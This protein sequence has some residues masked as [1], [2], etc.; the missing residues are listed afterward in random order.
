M[1]KSP[2]TFERN[3]DGSLKLFNAEEL[4]PSLKSEYEFLRKHK[5]VIG[6]FTV[7]NEKGGYVLP[8][9]ESLI[10]NMPPDALE[11]FII[12]RTEAGHPLGLY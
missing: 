4:P 9:A 1:E 2:I 11:S 10:G 6:S 12:Q 5:F 8:L 3:Q 7:G